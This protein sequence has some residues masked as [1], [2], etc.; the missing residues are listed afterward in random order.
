[1]RAKLLEASKRADG[2]PWH[3]EPGM[4]HFSV[5]DTKTGSGTVAHG[6]WYDNAAY[7]AQAA[8]MVPDL[9]ADLEELDQY[10]RANERAKNLGGV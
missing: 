6:V 3:I 7:I 5:I 8:N 10:R 4:A 9:L 2:L 1:M